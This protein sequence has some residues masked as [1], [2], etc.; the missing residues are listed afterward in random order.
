[1]AQLSTLGDIERFDFM[2]APNIIWPILL[3]V[4]GLICWLSI[5]PAPQARIKVEGDVSD[6]TASPARPV[7]S[8]DPYFIHVNDFRQILIPASKH[9]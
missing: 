8:Y 6:S 4:T 9:T 2:K 7:S 3:L 1:M 5:P